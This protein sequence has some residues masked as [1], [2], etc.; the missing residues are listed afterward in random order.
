V[1]DNGTDL[2][3]TRDMR[4]GVAKLLDGG[5]RAIAGNTD[6]EGR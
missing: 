2:F 5:S 4:T 6:F 3:E 1:L